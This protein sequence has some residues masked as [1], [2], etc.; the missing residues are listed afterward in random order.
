MCK[1]YCPSS[2]LHQCPGVCVCVLCCVCVCSCVFVCAS[3][4]H[5][6]YC[7]AESLHVNAA[8]DSCSGLSRFVPRR[9]RSSKPMYEIHIRREKPKNKVCSWIVC[10]SG[11]R[12]HKV[13]LV[14][15]SEGLCNIAEL[16]RVLWGKKKQ[17]SIKILKSIVQKSI[18]EIIPIIHVCITPFIESSRREKDDQPAQVSVLS[19]SRGIS[20]SG[21]AWLD[22]ANDAAAW[23]Q[24]HCGRWILCFSLS[25]SNKK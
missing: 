10:Q 21:T 20:V 8:A 9:R 11:F 6:N 23:M 19:R 22:A 1:M 15:G 13:L 24:S 14:C 4:N 2:L 18:K 17:V 3:L 12:D 5:F 7:G 16:Q 25:K